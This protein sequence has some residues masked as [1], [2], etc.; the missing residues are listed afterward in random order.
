MQR[1]MAKQAEAEREKR[2]KDYSRGW[3]IS[4]FGQTCGSGGEI[5]NKEPVALQLRYLQTLT[6]IGVE[7]NTTVVFPVP[8]D[9]IKDWDRIRKNSIE[10]Y[11]GS[12]SGVP[13][14]NWCWIPQAHYRVCPCLSF[15]SVASSWWIYGRKRQ[16][17]QAGAQTAL[18]L[19]RNPSG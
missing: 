18:R 17:F 1:A 10:I 14:T 3:G 4:G 8:I 16:G 13:D 19:Y 7:K 12:H 5:I 11:D 15:S 9:I 2:A 6:E